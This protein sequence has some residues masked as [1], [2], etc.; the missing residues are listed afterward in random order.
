MLEIEIEIKKADV[1]EEVAKTTAYIGGK[2]L[3]SNGNMM[4]DQVFVTDEDKKMIERFWIEAAGMVPNAAKRFITS[5]SDV[6]VDDS[7]NYVLNLSMSDRYDQ[8]LTSSIS[9]SMFS[10]FVSYI[11]AKWCEIV[12]KDS[13]REYSNN[14]VAMLASVKEKLFYKSRPKRT[15][16]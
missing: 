8:N 11:I 7:A 10:F 16:I 15:K 4:Y 13:V 6:S 9:S 3:D 12:S 2:N 14:A 1:Y 5:V